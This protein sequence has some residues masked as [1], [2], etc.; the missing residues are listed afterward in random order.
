MILMEEYEK[1]KDVLVFSQSVQFGFL[2]D[3]FNS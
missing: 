1:R 2:L 3:M